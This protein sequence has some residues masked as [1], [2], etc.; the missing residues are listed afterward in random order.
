MNSE[1]VR[2]GRTSLPPTPYEMAKF[3]TEFCINFFDATCKVG[4]VEES[5]SEIYKNAINKT[6]SSYRHKRTVSSDL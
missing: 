5:I 4:E 2:S 3:I 6:V 1:E